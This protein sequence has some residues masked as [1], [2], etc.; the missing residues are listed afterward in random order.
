MLD[1]SRRKCL[2]VGYNETSKAYRVCILEQ[3]KI[4]VRRDVKF[5]KDFASRKSHESIS[6]I[7]DEEQEA[8][9]VEL[10]SPVISRA[11]HQLSGEEGE[12]VAPS[13]SV[14]RPCWFT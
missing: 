14:R 11:V 9:K 2:F 13:T 3:R 10:G 8:W 7:E 1:P 5:E 4:M 12:T 6:V